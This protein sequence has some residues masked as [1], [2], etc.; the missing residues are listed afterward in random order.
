[1]TGI[2][3]MKALSIRQPWASLIIK[4]APVFKAV[5]NEDGSQR[6]EL[7]GV[8]FKDVENRNW[9]TNYRGRILVHASRKEDDFKSILYYLG[10]RGI[11]PFACLSLSSP[12]YS[13]RGYIIGEVDL[14]DVTTN[15]KSPWAEKGMYH[16]ILANPK[17]YSKPI[18]AR[19]KLG[20]YNYEHF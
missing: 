18:K 3:E 6:I 7:A 11:S 16:F 20:L 15:S 5:D 17:A 13:P 9:Q 2:N 12:E 19:G 10:E 14:I 1:M 8:A 4:G